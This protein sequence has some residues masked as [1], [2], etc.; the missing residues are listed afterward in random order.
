MTRPLVTWGDIQQ[1]GGSD[2]PARIQQ[3]PVRLPRQGSDRLFVVA[4][5]I[6]ILPARK[7]EIVKPGIVHAHG[8]CVPHSEYPRQWPRVQSL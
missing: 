5:D 1:P 6:R 3:G 4:G 8:H 7:L 2:N